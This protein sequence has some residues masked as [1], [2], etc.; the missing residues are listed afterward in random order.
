MRIYLVVDFFV[1]AKH[2]GEIKES[3]KKRQLCWP[4]PFTTKAIEHEGGSDTNCNCG[5]SNVTQRLGMV[6]RKIGNH[7]KIE[8]IQTNALLRSARI[9]NVSWL[10]MVTCCLSISSERPPA[11]SGIKKITRTI[12]II[13]TKS[14]LKENQD[15]TIIITV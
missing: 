3:E 11:I 1:L 12:I 4:C 15:N 14:F 9:L 13:I 5:T 7:R 10:P 6:R 8:T 2:K